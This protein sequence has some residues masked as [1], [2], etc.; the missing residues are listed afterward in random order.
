MRMRGHER[1]LKKG[2]WERLE[3][4]KGE[5]EWCNSISVQSIFFLKRKKKKRGNL[6]KKTSLPEI[7]KTLLH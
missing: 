4:G 7:L 1:G 5:G 6:L 2:S 3:R